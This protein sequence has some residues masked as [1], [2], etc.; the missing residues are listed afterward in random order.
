MPLFPQSN[1]IEK[2]VLGC[3][4]IA[5]KKAMMKDYVMVRI[6][7]LIQKTT[8]KRSILNIKTGWKGGSKSPNCTLLTPAH[9]V[10]TISDNGAKIYKKMK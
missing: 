9:H 8:P 5:G 4:V 6:Y 1:A 2:L 7:I 10:E 3:D